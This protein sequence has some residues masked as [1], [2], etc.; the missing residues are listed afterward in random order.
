MVDEAYARYGPHANRASTRKVWFR[1]VGK[2]YPHKAPAA[3]PHYPVRITPGEKGKR[4]AAAED[5]SMFAKAIALA[6]RSPRS[7]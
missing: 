4:F 2:E 5:A 1:A 3:I 6:N 7:P